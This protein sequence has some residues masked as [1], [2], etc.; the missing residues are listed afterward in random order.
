MLC[1]YSKETHNLLLKP[2]PGKPELKKV[3]E[4]LAYFLKFV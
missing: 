3:D 1:E 2:V 4:V